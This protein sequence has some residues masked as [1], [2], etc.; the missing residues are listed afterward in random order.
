VGKKPNYTCPY[1][2]NKM[3]VVHCDDLR[4]PGFYLKGGLDPRLPFV[5]EEMAMTA[6]RMRK[7]VKNAVKALVCPYTAKPLKLLHRKQE[8]LWYVVGDFFSPGTLYNFEQDLLYD[9]SFRGGKKPGFDPRD[10]TS[11]VV[12]DINIENS[13]PTQGLGGSNDAVEQGLQLLMED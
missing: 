4:H 3:E 1:T 5:S 13:D 11:I 7:G 12:G 6:M 10:K 8:E 9:M 2:G